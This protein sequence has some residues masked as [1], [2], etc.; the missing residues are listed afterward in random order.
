[1]QR[2]D[3]RVS[4]E[5]VFEG[6]E[7]GVLKCCQQ[8]ISECGV[9]VL[10]V[11]VL[12]TLLHALPNEFLIIEGVCKRWDSGRSTR[13]GQEDKGDWDDKHVLRRRQEKDTVHITKFA[14]Y[15]LSIYG[16][17]LKVKI[18]KFHDDLGMDLGFPEMGSVMVSMIK[19]MK[20]FIDTFTEQIKSTSN[21]PAEDHLF[22]ISEENEAMVLPDKQ[23][24]AF[25]HMAAQLLFVS[26]RAR[27]DIQTDLAF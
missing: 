27:R 8:L 3:H 23:A 26:E 16:K 5:R 19:Y 10:K 17:A 15:L 21:S 4:F 25:R 22:Q 11:I 6:R 13:V 12:T 24:V 2:C 14:C 18:V 20:K 9:N 1:M 7:L